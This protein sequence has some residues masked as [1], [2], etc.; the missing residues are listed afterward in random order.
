MAPIY[1]YDAVRSPRGKA[2]ADGGLAALSPQQLVRE[3]ADALAARCGEAARTPDALILGC[4]TQTGAQGGHVALLSKLHAELPDSVAALTLNN[5]CASGLSAIGQAVGRV[6]SGDAAA[7]L[8]G[9][10]EMMS[11]V[12][13]L[14]DRAG[15]YDNDEL[16]PAR[17]F[18]PPVLAADRL[19]HREGISRAELDAVALSSQ[20][21]AAASDADAALQSSRIAAGAL[22]GEECLRPR[23]SAESLAAMPA[24][25]G[26]LQAQY[27]AALDGEDFVPL[28]SLAHAPPICD[29]AGLALIGGEGLGPAPRARILAFAES[30]GDPAASLTAG[31]AAMDKALERAGLRLSDMDAVEFMEAFAVTIAKFLR[32]RDVDPTRV[33]ISGGHLAKG[34]PMGASGAILTSTLLD[35]LDARAGGYGLVVLTGAMGVG[36]A[37]IV[38]RLG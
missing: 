27:A 16:P 7:V 10:V 9:G 19:A 30:G 13:F 5:Y 17:R 37:M 18:V 25:F 2:R 29:G 35:T 32:D 3:Q 31:F 8:A 28:H 36:A 6:A 1:L 23:T 15:F 21:K 20:Q 34:H 22:H 4:V 33:N 38:E 14:S 11:A 26:E 24:A 12:P